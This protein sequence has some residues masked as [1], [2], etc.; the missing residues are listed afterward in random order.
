MIFLQKAD[1]TKEW[2]KNGLLHRK[3]R[4]PAIRKPDGSRQWYVNGKDMD[5]ASQIALGMMKSLRNKVFGAS[6][7]DNY[8]P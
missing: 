5:S 6:N 3:N 2:Y 4:L 8:K 1:G 7:S